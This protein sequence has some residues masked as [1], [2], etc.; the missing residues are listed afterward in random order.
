MES[1][2]TIWKDEQRKNEWK[3]EHKHFTDFVESDCAACEVV[4]NVFILSITIIGV[5]TI[6]LFGILVINDLKERAILNGV[7]QTFMVIDYRASR[8]IL[9]DS[10]I[11]IVDMNLEGGALSVIENGT[12]RESYVTIRNTNDTFNLTMQMG[13]VAYRLGERDVAY[14][15]G[16]VWS[17]YPDGSVMLSPPEFNYQ[18]V[19]LT[20]PEINISGNDFQGGRGVI[21]ILFKKDSLDVLYP[22]NSPNMSNPINY[23][24][25]GKIYMNITSDYYDAWADYARRL[26]YTKVETFP[27]DRKAAIEL[28]VVPN[29]LGMSVPIIDPVRAR[30]IPRIKEPLKNF[31]FR[32]YSSN[33]FNNFDWDIRQKIGNRQIIFHIFKNQ[34]TVGYSEDG[35]DGE[36]WGTVT[37]PIQTDVIGDYI[38]VNLLDNDTYLIYSNQNVGSTNSQFCQPFGSKISGINNPDYSWDNLVIN[39]TNGNK[40]QSVYN[41]TQHYISKIVEEGELSLYQCSPAGKHDPDSPST[42]IIDYDV[43]GDIT[44]L[45][46]TDNRVK[47]NID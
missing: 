19:T 3:R 14:E 42:M 4:G 27:D 35:K 15:G 11:Q 43:T 41:V 28:R 37:Y 21:S 29:W 1:K 45:H 40:T 44:Y 18:G 36:T 7:E 13:K 12:G 8:A 5:S 16:G 47:V 30:G 31:S 33:S 9:G 10:P 22:T 23:T 20:L 34:L 32:I 2:C 24:V 17:K 25:G 39:D 38:D 26:I 46:V 6:L